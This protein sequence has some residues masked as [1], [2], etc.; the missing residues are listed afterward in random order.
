MRS[1]LPLALAMSLITVGCERPRQAYGPLQTYNKHCFTPLPNW[2]TERD[3]LGHNIVIVPITIDE[4]GKVLWWDNE[5]V[6]DSKLQNYMGKV[7]Q[8]NP[9]P[10]MILD[11]NPKAPCSRVAAVRRIMNEIPMCREEYS[12]CSEGQN[13]RD[14]RENYPIS[15]LQTTFVPI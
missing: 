2:R 9:R 14:W 11:I 8:F 15:A 12:Y 10:Q 4:T 13:W 1:I 6:S 3:G 5:F 7:D